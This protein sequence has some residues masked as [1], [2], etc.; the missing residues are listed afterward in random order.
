M[1]KLTLSEPAQNSLIFLDITYREP[2]PPFT[3]YTKR[4]K[5]PIFV[6]WEFVEKL[7]ND[8][9]PQFFL[10]LWLAFACG[11]VA[12]ESRISG[13]EEAP[14]MIVRTNPIAVCGKVYWFNYSAD[15][16]ITPQRLLDET[17]PAPADTPTEMPF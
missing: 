15:K 13:Y 9:Q 4:E 1:Y 5:K 6:D 8:S 14:D 7:P 12:A 17:T 3:E 16:N 11:W 10:N 2:H